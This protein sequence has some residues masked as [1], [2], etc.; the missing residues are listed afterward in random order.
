[1]RNKIIIHCN[2]FYILLG[3]LLKNRDKVTFSEL[4]R[5]KRIL[6]K[7]LP[8]VHIHVYNSTFIY[9]V[10]NFGGFK[11]KEHSFY[12]A[13]HPI[14]NNEEVFNRFLKWDGDEILFQMILNYFK[15]DK[16]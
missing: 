7:K 12:K 8:N 6:R 2:N 16:K 10:E 15:G 3:H 9:T 5:L 11:L 13:D 14:W 1:M 4:N